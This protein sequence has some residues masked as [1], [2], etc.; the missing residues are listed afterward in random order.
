MGNLI[1]FCVGGAISVIINDSIRKN[2]NKSKNNANSTTP[3]EIDLQ[4]K[5]SETEIT[6]NDESADSTENKPNSEI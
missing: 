4:T 6:E 3:K 2:L 5:E 1:V